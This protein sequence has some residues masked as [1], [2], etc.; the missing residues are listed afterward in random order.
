MFNFAL[1]M[2]IPSAFRNI[3]G[4]LFIVFGCLCVGAAV[5]A[6]F[7]YPE[8]AR[9]SLEEIEEMFRPGGPKPWQTRPG[10]SKTDQHVADYIE[11]KAS[12]Q[13]EEDI[14]VSD[15]PKVVRK[16][17]TIGTADQYETV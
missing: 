8:T 9:K 13:L 17:G 14:G 15:K 5:Q 12:M 2:F 6:W 11:R 16:D 3:G 1:G 10:Q 7:L 4:N